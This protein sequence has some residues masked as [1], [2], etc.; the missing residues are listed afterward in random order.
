M[1]RIDSRRARVTSVF[2]Y[3]QETLA[4]LAMFINAN[5]VAI[6]YGFVSQ[7]EPVKECQTN[8]DCV[9][10]WTNCNCSPVPINKK[11]KKHSTQLGSNGCSK[12]CEHPA[13]EYTAKCN[14]GH[15]VLGD[16]KGLPTSTYTH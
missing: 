16:K 10:A 13:D 8:S 12:Q 14:E 1:T 11:Y 6:S 7:V 5:F 4:L 2:S 15:C 9:V 3:A